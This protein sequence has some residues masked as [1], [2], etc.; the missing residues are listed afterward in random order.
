MEYII[1]DLEWDNA[2]FPPKKR[3]VNQILQIGAVRLNSDFELIDT[4]EAT[5]CSSISK[6]VSE[7]FSKLTGITTEKMRKG[8]SLEKAVEGYN[9][10]SKGAQVTMTWSDTDLYT[11]I[12]NQ[13]TLLKG[14]AEFL[15]DKYLDLQKLV[16]GELRQR[17]YESKN[18]ISLEAAAVMLNVDTINF[19]LHTALDDS[20]LCAELLKICY[21]KEHFDALLRDTKKPDF[22]ARLEFKAYPISDI[23]DEN[24]DKK[25]L[26]FDCPRC[27]DKTVRLGKFK[28]RNRWFVANFKC[29][30]CDYKFSG[31]VSFKQKFDGV[32]VKRRIC[33]FKVRKK[34]NDMQSLPEKV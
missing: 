8:I 18:Q 2:F 21:K 16:Q 15:F 1:L 30:K 7:R 29:K 14:K 5:V 25:N 13:K 10:F 24:I 20:L 28:Y 31:R 9:L 26:I 6:K 11:I 4:Y 19:E 3:F 27:S 34:Q 22:F 12:D 32:E 33:E 17:G 23:N